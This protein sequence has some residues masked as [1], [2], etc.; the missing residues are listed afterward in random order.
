MLCVRRR[1]A[2]MA[3]VE[4][5][6]A[7]APVEVVNEVCV[8][9][10]VLAQSHCAAPRVAMAKTLFNA[11]ALFTLRSQRLPYAYGKR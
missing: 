2:A 3:D 10:H 5:E 9:R 6:T 4:E 8:V 7:L 1:L 11:P